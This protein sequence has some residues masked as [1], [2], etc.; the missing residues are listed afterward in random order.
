MR[1]EC[2]LI[3]MLTSYDIPEYRQQAFRNGAD[4]FISKADDACLPDIIA[5]VEKAV[6]DKNIQ[7]GQGRTHTSRRAL[8][9]RR[10]SS[11]E[12]SL[13]IAGLDLA[14]CLL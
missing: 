4:Y 7:T 5:C 14:A 3:V 2:T 8:F 1:H 6:A 13:P 9:R 11:T 12:D 10:N